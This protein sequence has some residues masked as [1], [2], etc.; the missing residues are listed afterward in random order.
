MHLHMCTRNLLVNICVGTYR[1]L[2]THVHMYATQYVC[3]HISIIVIMFAACRNLYTNIST[4]YTHISIFMNVSTNKLTY[5]LI[6]KN[7]VC[8]LH[9]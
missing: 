6:F 8:T 5:I 4:L 7:Y 1:Q 3:I 2:Y 9:I